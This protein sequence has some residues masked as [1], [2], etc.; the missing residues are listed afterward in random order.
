MGLLLFMRAE[1]AGDLRPVS[2]DDTF[3]DLSFVY[4]LSLISG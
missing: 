4:I 2:D 1:L 3:A